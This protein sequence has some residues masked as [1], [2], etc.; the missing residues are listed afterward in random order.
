MRR[1]MIIAATSVLALAVA[2]VAIAVTTAAG[3]STTTATFD[4]A[5]GNIQSRTCTGQDNKTYEVTRGRYTGTVDFSNPSSDLDGPLS[6]NARTVYSTSDN[7]GYVDGTFRVKDGDSRVSGRFS[8]TLDSSH[9]L[10]GFLDG[11]SWG[12]HAR[13]LGNL[14]AELGTGSF[15][16]GKIGA[17]SSTATAAVIAGPVCK[18]PKVDNHSAK[19]PDQKTDKKTDH[20]ARPLSI[21]GE[22]TAVDTSAISVKWAGPAT[23]TCKTDSTSPTTTG[24]SVGTK[25]EMKCEKVGTDWFLRELKLHA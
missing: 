9:N 1:L 6:I 22:V 24:F 2:A 11:W 15:V 3:V 17:G 20:A 13:V 4:A 25:V 12:T 8:G 21:K 16:N 18:G 14:S 19:K 5:K 10:V 7:L 23:V